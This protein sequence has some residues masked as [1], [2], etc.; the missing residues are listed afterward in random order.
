MPRRQQTPPAPPRPELVALLSACKEQPQED[1]PRL[2]L[3]DWLEEHGEPERAEL[4][5]VQCRLARSEEGPDWPALQARERELLRQSHQ[6]LLAPLGRP[7]WYYRLRRG[8]VRL[9]ARGNK[10]SVKALLALAQTEAWAWVEHL[11]LT[12]MTPKA[13]ADLAGSPIL[14][15]VRELGAGPPG[16][17]EVARVVASTPAFA[18][19]R[20]L[21]LGRSF[22]RE[23][24]AIAGA[25]HLA[26]LVELDL[27]DSEM[28]VEGLRLLL[29]S[30][31]LPRV[32]KLS[33]YDCK[34]GPG[35]ARALA[36]TSGMPAL[37][38]VDLSD[39]DLGPEGA[40]ALADCARESLCELDVYHNAL[41]DEG[42]LTLAATTALPGL[43]ALDLYD[44]NLGDAG[45]RALAGSDLLGRL[46]FLSLGGNPITVRGVAA[47]VGSPRAAAL[48]KLRITCT[49]LRDELGRVLAASPHLGRLRHLCLESNSFGPA[50][51]R[52][53]LEADWLPG[54]REL[55][56]QMNQLG[57]EGA[58]ALAASP[59]LAGCREL[60]LWG[61]K[62]VGPAGVLAL[63]RS[64]HLAGLR[65]LH[66]TCHPIGDEGARAILESPHLGGLRR[67]G[68]SDEGLSPEVLATLRARFGD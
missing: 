37:E 41:G 8:L 27:R 30:P 29:D 60:S 65:R 28:G 6:T 23:G 66:M 21:S 31:H 63:A 48:E 47:L 59:A 68:Y 49:Y 53:L 3:G 44:N 11:S 67:F 9:D 20:S 52:A 55:E 5:R 56:L 26:G 22:T 12:G 57:D 51:V 2:V 46:T 16:A 61:G 45:L 7:G 58:Q 24:A 13:M 40:R 1:T 39:N 43:R 32:G 33:L 38:S 35:A 18:G 4:V 36:E 14:A 15:E 19:L 34:L 17:D 64:P 10:A 42:V 50:G 62:E 54:L 25:A